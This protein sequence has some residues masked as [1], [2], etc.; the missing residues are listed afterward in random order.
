MLLPRVVAGQ[1]EPAV[2]QVPLLLSLPSLNSQQQCALGVGRLGGCL[3]VQVARLAC[4]VVSVWQHCVT[5][6]CVVCVGRC[7]QQQ[8]H[9]QR[10][11]D[12]CVFWRHFGLLAAIH[13]YMAA[14]LHWY[15]R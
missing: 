14:A 9:T 11:D 3:G 8:A 6:Q 1:S 4:A 7:L 2:R 15:L 12:R 10:L 13:T 5:A